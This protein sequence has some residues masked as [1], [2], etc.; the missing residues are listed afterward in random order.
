MYNLFIKVVGYNVTQVVLCINDLRGWRKQEQEIIWIPKRS[1]ILIPPFSPFIHPAHHNC[2]S[3]ENR[4]NHPHHQC[5]YYRSHHHHHRFIFLSDFL[6]SSHMNRFH[7]SNLAPIL[8]IF[9]FSFSLNQW[10]SSKLLTSHEDFSS[11]IHL[12]CT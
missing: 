9:P 1:R 3:V 6:S 2:E 12:T 8:D 4:T 7:P 10:K 11:K 5:H